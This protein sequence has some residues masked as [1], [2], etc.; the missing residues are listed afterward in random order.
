MSSLHSASPRPH[1]TLKPEFTPTCSWPCHCLPCHHQQPGSY[2]FSVDAFSLPL[3]PPFSSIWEGS[4]LLPWHVSFFGFSQYTALYTFL[5]HLWPILHCLQEYAPL[6]CHWMLEFLKAQVKSPPL[7][8]SQ[9]LSWATH[10]MNVLITIHTQM[11]HKPRIL[12]SGPV[13]DYLYISF[14]SC[15]KV[16]WNV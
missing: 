6:S 7:T 11:I 14:L 3:I 16:P 15:L 4:Q 10:P 12:I 5:L 2:G 13:W 8:Y 9:L 1:S